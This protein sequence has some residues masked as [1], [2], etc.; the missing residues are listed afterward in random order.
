MSATDFSFYVRFGRRQTA[1]PKPT[2]V[3]KGTLSA[4]FA[5]KHFDSTGKLP[6]GCRHP[7]VLQ[8]AMYG[9]MVLNWHITD[10]WG[11]TLRLTAREH[12]IALTLEEMYELSADFPDAP[13]W[14][15]KA[16]VAMIRKDNPEWTGTPPRLS[17]LLQPRNVPRSTRD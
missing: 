11:Y 10:I 3:Q 6:S 13:C 1:L 14:V 9:K 2:R 4:D 15:W 17:Q 7:R 8:A 16:L 5:F 12:S